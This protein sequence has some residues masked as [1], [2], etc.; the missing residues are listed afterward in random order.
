MN[1]KKI[2]LFLFIC[3]AQLIGAQ[4][5]VAK[6]LGDFTTVK[7]FDRISVTLISSNENK[8]EISGNRSQEVETVNKNGDLKIRLPLTK[9]LKGE[10]LTAKLYFKSI[11]G[12]EV[13][14]GSSAVSEHTFKAVSFYISVKEGATVEIILNVDKVN[15]RANSGGIVNLSGAAKTQDIVV[16]SGGI[17][18]AKDLKST[19]ATV[20]INAG[21]NVA[22]NASDLVDAKTRAGGT[23]TVYGNPKQINKKATLGGT[24]KEAK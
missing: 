22:V 21:G 10:E 3:T 17:V 20:S 7:I 12:L 15:I 16:T 13:S 9:L 8:I 19:Q 23:I 4:G 14:E 18:N 1:M 11:D 24:I 2:I 5:T 6:S